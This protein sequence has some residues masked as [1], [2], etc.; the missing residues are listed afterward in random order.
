[1]A[2]EIDRAGG[3]DAALHARLDAL[4]RA[5]AARRDVHH[6]IAA[7]ESGDG[8]FRW[9]RAHGEANPGGPPMQAET[10]FFIASVDKLFTA[11]VTMRF[12]EAGRLRLDEPVRTYLPRAIVDG[13][14]IFR[15]T[16]YSGRITL[17]HLLG[18]TSG[19]PDYLEDRPRRGRSLVDELAA[20]GDRGW[21]L[22]EMA[23]RVRERLTAHFPPQPTDAPRVKARYSDTNYRLLDATLE[24]IDGRPAH[25]VFARELFEPLDMRHTWVVGGPGPRAPAA[26]PATLWFGAQPLEIPRAMASFGGVFSTLH[27]TLRFLRA[28]VR[29]ELFADPRTYA[30]MQGRWNRFGLPLDAAAL[31]SPNWP[32]EYG[33]GLMRFRLPRWLT[34]FGAVPPV[35]GHSGS[36]GSWLFHCP[37]LDVF[38]SGTVDQ[39]T[40]GAVPYRFLP[41]VL[42]AAQSALIGSRAAPA[43]GRGDGRA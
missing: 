17:R 23:A 19:L 36:T 3:S 29:G 15:G 26:P 24:E 14:H 35:V 1:M 40:A 37:D 8:A 20:E 33:L 21:S 2:R 32:I 6:A 7:V 22:E 25:D 16:D 18:H 12:V 11:A 27:D 39:A 4:F 42:R 38:V 31:R 9:A 10:P 34:P 43:R 13:L 5:V 30:A 28:L 41:K